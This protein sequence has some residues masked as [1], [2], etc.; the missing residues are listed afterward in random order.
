M[1]ATRVIRPRTILLVTAVLVV[2]AGIIV[3]VG[4]KAQ[5]PAV[6][7]ES[8]KARTAK[9]RF[10]R[11]SSPVS[12]AIDPAAFSPGACMSYGPTSGDRHETVFLD[13][14]HGGA[15]PGATGVT[16]HGASIDEAEVN[17]RIELDVTALLRAEGYRVV[18]S[19]L[20]RLTVLRRPAGLLTAPH[21]AAVVAASRAGRSS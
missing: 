6:S 8:G 1:S 15:D 14:G 16:G 5:R 3:V 12:E 10:S 20:G 11:V 2:T 18:V 9:V 21:P 19:R 13:A 7:A 4:L 17:L